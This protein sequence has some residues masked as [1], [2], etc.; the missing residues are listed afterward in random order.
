MDSN[1]LF[2]RWEAAGSPPLKYFSSVMREAV[3]RRLKESVREQDGSVSLQSSQNVLPNDNIQPFRKVLQHDD[4]QSDQKVAQDNNMHPYHSVS[5]SHGSQRS[6]LVVDSQVDIRMLKERLQGASSSQNLQVYKTRS[7]QVIEKL[8]AENEKLAAELRGRQAPMNLSDVKEQ[9][10]E[11]K[12]N[13]PTKCAPLLNVS[14]SVRPADKRSV[15][16][17][18]DQCHQVQNHSIKGIFNSNLQSTQH[19]GKYEDTLDIFC[20]IQSTIEPFDKE[21]EFPTPGG[22][23]IMRATFDKNNF[24]QAK[25]ETEN[26]VGKNAN[27]VG[28]P[29]YNQGGNNP[30]IGA[31]SRGM[32]NGIHGLVGVGKCQEYLSQ[33]ISGP[34]NAQY[35]PILSPSVV[36]LSSKSVGVG[37]AQ[38]ISGPPNAQYPSIWSPNVVNPSPNS[39]G[40]GTGQNTVN[41][42]GIPPGGQR[43]DNPSIGPTVQ[44]QIRKT[45]I[46]HAYIMGT[47]SHEQL[48]NAG[49]TPDAVINPTT[50]QGQVTN[51]WTPQS[52][53]LDPAIPQ[54]QMLIAPATRTEVMGTVPPHGQIMNSPRAQI[55]NSPFV[56]IMTSPIGRIKGSPQGQLMLSSPTRQ[57]PSV[58]NTAN[59]HEQQTLIKTSKPIAVPGITDPQSSSN[60]WITITGNRS[61]EKTHSSECLQNQQLHRFQIGPGTSLAKRMKHA[62][63]TGHKVKLK[64]SRSNSTAAPGTNHPLLATQVHNPQGSGDTPSG[65]IGVGSGRNCFSVLALDGGGRSLAAKRRLR[66]HPYKIGGGI[67]PMAD[68]GGVLL[69]LSLQMNR[70]KEIDKA[71]CGDN[72]EYVTMA[73]PSSGL[74]SGQ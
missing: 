32:G 73:D 5:H 44:G 74:P 65:P 43:G 48:M 26:V 14:E 6:R 50:P 10:D 46:P 33:N 21:V 38:N 30:S 7:K 60:R 25:K 59:F 4:V 54:G 63:I 72:P 52:Q 31:N 37:T 28:I 20:K 8:A 29:P 58:P 35:P 39:L 51:T 9:C 1:V 18:V 27:G 2:K 55:M 71:G 69:R 36:N 45:S 53:V 41:G 17:K 3:E 62:N 47:T 42:M 49:S 40:V 24:E 15:C 16:S 23:V 12:S 61:Y 11:L 66:S 34:P 56:R 13:D 67:Y 22:K 68:W 70:R 57:S 64:M 19:L